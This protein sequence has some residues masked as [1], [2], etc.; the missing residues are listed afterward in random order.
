MHAV[1]FDIDGTLLQS[2]TV[3]DALYREAVRDV[4]GDV[5]FRLS[6]TDYSH[7]SDSGI[8]QEVFSDNAIAYEPALVEAIQTCFVDSLWNFVAVGPVLG[9]LESY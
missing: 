6:L 4:L 8:L 5:Q 1:V 9:G 2:A 3:D 7:V